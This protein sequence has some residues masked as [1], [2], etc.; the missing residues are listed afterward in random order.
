M[1]KR[2]VINAAFNVKQIGARHTHGALRKSWWI[3][4]MFTR[5][6]IKFAETTEKTNQDVRRNIFST[7]TFASFL[8]FFTFFN[9]G[10]ERS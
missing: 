5:Q 9:L 7:C 6:P 3:A 10:F 2:S 4:A 1:Q 8:F